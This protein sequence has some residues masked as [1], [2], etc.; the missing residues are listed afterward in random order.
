[1][2]VGL[3]PASRIVAVVPVL[4]ST[5]ATMAALE[6]IT[7]LTYPRFTASSGL[8]SRYFLHLCYDGAYAL[9]PHSCLWC[10][11]DVDSSRLPPPFSSLLISVARFAS[12]VVGF[13]S[14]SVLF[15]FLLFLR[16]SPS[17]LLLQRV[18]TSSVIT[19]RPF[20]LYLSSWRVLLLW[21][22]RESNPRVTTIRRSCLSSRP[23]LL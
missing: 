1:M 18:L 21:K 8:L 9:R 20:A 15:G 19:L 6:S 23:T 17:I 3:S 12:A 7:L 14:F 5:V 2:Q 4:S 10:G 22:V 13:A 11:F 16:S